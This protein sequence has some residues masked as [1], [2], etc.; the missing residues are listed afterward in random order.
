MIYQIWGMWIR[1]LSRLVVGGHRD[2][3]GTVL[4]QA[5]LSSLSSGQI[6]IFREGLYDYPCF[7][8]LYQVVR[9]LVLQVFPMLKNNLK[10]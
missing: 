2:K 10:L 8:L 3:S 9:Q 5:A 6:V 7:Y 4:R 1:I